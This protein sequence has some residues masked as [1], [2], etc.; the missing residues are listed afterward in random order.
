[1]KPVPNY[2]E[3]CEHKVTEP[4]N[5]LLHKIPKSFRIPL[6]IFGILLFW[7]IGQLIGGIIGN[8]VNRK[9][10]T[11]SPMV[12]SNSQVLSPKNLDEAKVLQAMN[13]RCNT[14]NNFEPTIWDIR[15]M[16]VTEVDRDTGEPK[17][18]GAK[19]DEKEG[20]Y[21]S[22]MVYK[23]PCSLPLEATISAEIRSK[24]SMG[25][26]YE[27]EDVLQIIVGDGDMRSIRYKIHKSNDRKY[28]WDYIYYP[29]GSSKITH[30]ISENGITSDSQIDFTIKL[31]AMDQEEIEIQIV[32]SYKPIGGNYKTQE[33]PPVRVKSFNYNLSQNIGKFTRVGLNDYSFKGTES[34]F[35]PLRFSIHS[36]A[37]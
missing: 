12:I 26:I 5:L 29:N 8:L 27:F 6:G 2:I 16:R 25:L 28:G 31:R 17:S 10:S 15:S 20:S 7:V 34:E 11:I 13:D 4:F 3:E 23:I 9:N 30:R 14:T 21:Q 22:L 37:R 32:L 18:Y 24:F 36:P 19:Q 1:M 35:I 33:F